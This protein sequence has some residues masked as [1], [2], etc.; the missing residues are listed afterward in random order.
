MKSLDRIAAAI[1]T[2]NRFFGGIAMGCTLLL[3][4]LTVEQVIARYAFGASSVG[5]QELEWHLFG[6][7][8]LLAGGYTLQMDAHVRID[9]FYGRFSPR[10]RAWVNLLGV[11]LFLLPSC[12]LIASYG[13]EYARTARIYPSSLPIDHYTSRWAG[14]GTFLYSLLALIEALLRRTILV[15]EGS[16]DPGGLEARWLIKA[17]IPLGAVLMALQGISLLI[18]SLEVLRL[19][20][21]GGEPPSQR[22]VS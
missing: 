12:Y 1:D 3:V 22:A 13:I 19:D 18:R 2:L 10:A 7:I 20:R 5:M 15:G 8:F 16:P 4:L 14:Q 9:I 17:A 11:L 6:L 21:A